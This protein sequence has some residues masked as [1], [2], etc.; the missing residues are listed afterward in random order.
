M[1]LAP[2]VA[3]KAGLQAINLVIVELRWGKIEAPV[4]IAP[5]VGEGRILGL[6]HFADTNQLTAPVCHPHSRQLRYKGGAVKL[7]KAERTGISAGR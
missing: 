3:V 1:R 7:S 5:S 4:V 2:L 6:R